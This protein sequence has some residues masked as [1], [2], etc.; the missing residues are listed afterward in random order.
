[1]LS[2]IDGVITDIRMINLQL[3]NFVSGWSKDEGRE[4]DHD[5]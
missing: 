3:F 1:M 5:R 2:K 4:A